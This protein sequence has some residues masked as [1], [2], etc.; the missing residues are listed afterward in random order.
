M[1]KS[2]ARRVF[3]RFFHVLARFSPGARAIPNT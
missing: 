3:N 1:N 2:L